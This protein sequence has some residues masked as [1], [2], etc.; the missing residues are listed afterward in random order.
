MVFLASAGVANAQEPENIMIQF[1]KDVYTWTD[2]VKITIIAHDHN[3]SGNIVDVLGESDKDNETR[4]INNLKKNYR[5]N[6][7][8]LHKKGFQLKE[9]PF[10]KVGFS[11]EVAPSSLSHSLDFF[12]GNFAFQG[13]SSQI[14]PLVLNPKPGENVLDMAAAPG[15]VITSHCARPVD[16]ASAASFSTNESGSII[17]V[18]SQVAA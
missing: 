13:A 8:K 3:K 5:H 12:K 18:Q 2:K 7:E 10:S 17:A 11:V 4:V 15:S 1:D 14:P 6:I 16:P 9:L